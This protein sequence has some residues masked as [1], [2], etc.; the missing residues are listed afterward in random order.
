MD[1][2]IKDYN[3]R[4]AVDGKVTLTYHPFYFVCR[5]NNL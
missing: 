5:K 3:A 4:F 2:F 1:A